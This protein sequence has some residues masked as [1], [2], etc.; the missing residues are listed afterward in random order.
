[1]LFCPA[2][3]FFPRFG[4]ST[5]RRENRVLWRFALEFLSLT[6]KHQSIMFS[7]MRTT[8]NYRSEAVTM[9]RE[10]AR[11]RNITEGEAASLLIL[12]GGAGHKAFKKRNGILLARNDG[13][14][15]TREEVNAALY[16]E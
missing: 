10:L 11:Q 14:P 4:S 8:W 13:V 12:N 5:S 15:V 3:F 2:F 1:M 16:D 9:V 6:S 7:D